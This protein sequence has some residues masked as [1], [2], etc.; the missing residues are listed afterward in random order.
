VDDVF[1]VFS[2]WICEYFTEYFCTNPHEGNSLSRLS[3]CTLGIRV[4]VAS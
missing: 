2:D 1:D 3:L 4:T